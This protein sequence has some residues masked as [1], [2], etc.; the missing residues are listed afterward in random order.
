MGVIPG[1]ATISA[2][3]RLVGEQP[4][5]TPNERAFTRWDCTLGK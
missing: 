5:A 4:Y 3:H 2:I 1:A